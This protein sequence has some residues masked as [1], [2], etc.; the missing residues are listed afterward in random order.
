M[1]RRFKI[2]SV[3]GG[4]LALLLVSTMMLLTYNGSCRSPPPL[5]ANLPLMRAM[6]YR[7]Y[8]APQRV[9]FENLE[10]PHPAPD[11]VLVKVLVAA[12]NPLDWHYLK[13][14]PY[15][16]RVSSGVGT[17]TDIHL[18]VDFA[19]TVE[20]V[21][22][23]VTRFKAGDRVF[24]GADGSF[25]EYV[26]P[27]AE[28]S[29][30]LLPSNVSFD[31]AAALPVAGV[32]ALQALRDKGRVQPGMKILINGASGG[33]GT[34]AVQIA[35]ILGATVT[36]V[37]STRN[38]AMVRSIG[39]DKVIDYTREDFTRLP[40]RYD[41][42]IDNVGSHTQSEY[43]RVLSPKGSVI[44]VGGVNCGVCLGP[45]FSWLGNSILAPFNS[46]KR[47]MFLA[48]LNAEDLATLSGWMAEGKLSSVIDRKYALTDVPAALG[49]LEQGHARGKVLIDLTARMPEE[50]GA[51]LKTS[52]TAASRQ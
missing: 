33:V 35:K 43:R 1:T 6:V 37:C 14:E 20:E 34:Y 45:L 28:G 40:D 21:G 24:G 39:A 31:Q 4:L 2:L 46:Q 25:A 19:G 52:A 9:R 18:G 32:T 47:L 48:K 36:G 42:I 11:R 38:A 50:A 17:P 44:M 51:V 29:I 12:A 30:A 22:S 7:C 10:K 49:Y 15:F 23:G 41:L 13:G 8:G 3:I 27:R 5:A 26:T 16:M